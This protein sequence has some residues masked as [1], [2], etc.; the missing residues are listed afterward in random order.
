MKA[1]TVGSIIESVCGKCNDVMGHT[2]MAMVGTEIIKVEC[3]AC[4]SVHKYRP[5]VRLGG[6]KAAVTMKKGRDGE[7]VSSRQGSTAKASRPAMPKSAARR[8]SAAVAAYEAWQAAMRRHG[9]EPPRPYAMAESFA[10]GECIDHPVFGRGEVTAV[11]PPDKMD[12]LFE[13]GTKRLLCNKI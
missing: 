9:D 2:I 1:H 4:G 8:P 10:K 7:P 3:R 6:G 5:P 12:I 13:A 11:V